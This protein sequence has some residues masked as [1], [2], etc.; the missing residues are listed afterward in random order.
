M[1]KGNNATQ[2]SASRSGSRPAQT[3]PAGVVSLTSRGATSITSEV[4]NTFYSINLA[5]NPYDASTDGAYKLFTVA[6]DMSKFFN[7]GVFSAYEYYKVIECETTFS[8]KSSPDDGGPILGEIQWALDK[9][10]RESE[11]VTEICNRSTLQTRAFDN[12]H[13]RQILEWNPYLVE[14]SDTEGVPG[15]QVDYVQPRSRW[16]NTNQVRL[17]RFG[18]LRCIVTIPNGGAYSSAPAIQVRHRVVIHCKGQR[19]VQT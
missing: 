17:H 9:D 1:V 12:N 15:A 4:G 7:S 18:T 16:L 14:V 3:L 6:L 2:P 5:G 10:S 8:M 13:T 19:S 11:T